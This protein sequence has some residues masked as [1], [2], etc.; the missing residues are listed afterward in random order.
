[1]PEILLEMREYRNSLEN[2][3]TNSLTIL[4]PDGILMENSPHDI[5]LSSF[6][7]AKFVMIRVNFM[8]KYGSRVSS[9]SP[10]LSHEFLSALAFVVQEAAHVPQF[11]ILSGQLRV[12]LQSSNQR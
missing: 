10:P 12:P 4:H 1:M 7:L 3:A 2:L 11:L 9:E 5:F 8:T 6:E